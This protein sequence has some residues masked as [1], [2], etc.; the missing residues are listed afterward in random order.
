LEELMDM[1]YQ[2]LNV[3]AD[4]IILASGFGEVAKAFDRLRSR[5]VADR[6]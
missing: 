5:P 1:G 2:F 6:R 3:S 4:V